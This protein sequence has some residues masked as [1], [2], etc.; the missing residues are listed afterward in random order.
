MF[1]DVDLKGTVQHQTVHRIELTADGPFGT[2]RR[3]SP[4]KSQIESSVL[5]QWLILEF[6]DPLVVNLL[7]H[8]TWYQRKNQMIEDIAEI[9]EN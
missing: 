3:L 5:N 1:G 7:H 9:I 2:P 6:V 4:E 8:Y